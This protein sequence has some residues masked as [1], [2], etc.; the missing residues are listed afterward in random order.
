MPRN[1]IRL[2]NEA[3]EALRVEIDRDR[4]KDQASIDY[5]RDLLSVLRDGRTEDL[6][7][8]ESFAA[9]M[10][11]MINRR[12]DGVAEQIKVQ[13]ARE[14]AHLRDLEGNEPEKLFDP[15]KPALSEPESGD[16]KV[17][18]INRKNAGA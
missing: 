9:N 16:G 18:R 14:E 11:M 5:F 17:T 6:D 10:K 3:A 15:E 1:S 7:A 13:I 4:A 12:H 8:V 2:Q